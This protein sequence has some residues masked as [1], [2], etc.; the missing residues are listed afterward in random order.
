MKKSLQLT[1]LVIFFIPQL[2]FSM[3]VAEA[4]P[5]TRQK[6]IPM[7]EQIM[8]NWT[9]DLYG[10]CSSVGIKITASQ[11][12]GIQFSDQSVILAALFINVGAIYSEEF[13]QRY[14]QSANDALKNVLESY[15]QEFSNISQ[16]RFNSHMQQCA[17]ALNN[18][19]K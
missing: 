3:T 19:I 10:K 6:L 9:P 7:K 16:E 1:L 15:T 5:L 12:K 2:C 13:S 18:T 14:G 17:N 11:I 4:L 8:Q